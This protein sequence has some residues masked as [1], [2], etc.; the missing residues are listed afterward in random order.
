VLDGRILKKRYG[1]YFIQSLP[2]TLTSFGSFEGMLRD[3]E[4]FL[5]GV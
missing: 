1:V 3:T 4:N 2:E 5:F